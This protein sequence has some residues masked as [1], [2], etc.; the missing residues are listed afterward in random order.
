MAQPA[1]SGTCPECSDSPLSVT[2]NIIGILTFA[3]G[4]FAFC[5]TLFAVLRGANEEICRIR[6]TLNET[7][8]EIQDIYPY[9]TGLELE[10]DED[11]K[12]HQALVQ[13][14]LEGLVDARTT[15]SYRLESIE[16]VQSGLCRPLGWWWREKEIQGGLL[17]IENHKRQIMIIQL[18]FLLKKVKKQSQDVEKIMAW[19]GIPPS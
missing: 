12:N 16:K 17:R 19:D 2:G 11:L 1:M 18:T 15:V 6:Q 7:E 4:V 5:A 3:L 10:A 8:S 13:Q 9:F 14:C